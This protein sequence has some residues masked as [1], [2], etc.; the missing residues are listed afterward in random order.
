MFNRAKMKSLNINIL[1]SLI[2]NKQAIFL[3]EVPSPFRR[4]LSRFISGETLTG[5]ENGRVRISRSL[6]KRWLKK[7]WMKGFDQ[8]V[9]LIL[10]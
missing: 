10:K 4:D 7:I 9:S 1:P 3:D 6:F 2:R 5:C 8:S